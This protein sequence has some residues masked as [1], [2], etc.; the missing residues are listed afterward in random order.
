M[1]AGR[2]AIESY[3]KLTETWEEIVIRKEVSIAMK[4]N[5][6]IGREVL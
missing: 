6:S 5:W 1:K 4:K 3:W 2:I